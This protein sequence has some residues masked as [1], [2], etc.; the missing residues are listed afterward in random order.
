MITSLQVSSG[1]SISI[2]SIWAAVRNKQSPNSANTSPQ[3]C[4][5]LFPERAISPVSASLCARL[6]AHFKAAPPLRFHPWHKLYL[7]RLNWGYSLFQAVHISFWIAQ[8][9]WSG[10]VLTPY[11]FR[12]LE[13]KNA[14]LKA[15]P[16]S[17]QSDCS[18]VLIADLVIYCC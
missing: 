10:C 16:S 6:R 1:A 14:F 7:E 11:L 5:N 4:V 13:A 9:L 2:L 12:C 8:Q 17:N 18:G 15:L 3:T